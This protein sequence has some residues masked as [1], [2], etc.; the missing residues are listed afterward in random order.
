LPNTFP[1]TSPVLKPTMSTQ[2]PG[3]ETFRA[4]R[5]TGP[6][7][8]ILSFI[9]YLVTM[10]TYPFPGESARLVA[11]HTTVQP[12][13]ELDHGIWL[14]VSRIA[15]NI[16]A[17]TLA[18]RLSLFSAL[19]AAGVVYLVFAFHLTLV[20]SRI[21]TERFA[22]GQIVSPA[23]RE[24]ASLISAGSAAA[25]TATC[26][27]FWTV[28]NRPHYLAF[29]IFLFALAAYGALLF[30]HH[31]KQKHYYGVCL[32]AGLAAVEFPGFIVASPLIGFAIVWGLQSHGRLNLSTLLK[33]GIVFLA[34]FSTLILLA[35]YFYY[36]PLAQAQGLDT[37]REALVY[38]GYKH[39]VSLVRS[40]P[41]VGWLLTLCLCV[42]PWILVVGIQ[43]TQGGDEDKQKF[44]RRLSYLVLSGVAIG[45]LYG[46]PFS[47]WEIVKQQNT[48]VLPV[49]F[50]GSWAGFLAGFWYI[51]FS[52]TPSSG[53]SRPGFFRRSIPAFYIV[54]LA[55]ILLG[56]VVM[57][58]RRAD[59]S[60]GDL[61]SRYADVIVEK[62]GDRR[63]V[64]GVGNLLR[65]IRIS[66]HDSGRE[67]R[68]IDVAMARFKPYQG[69]LRSLHKDPDIRVAVSLGIVPMMRE[70]LEKSPD[71]FDS[72][73]VV[74]AADVLIPL[75]LYPIPEGVFYLPGAQED[76]DAEALLN[77]HRK[78]WEEVSFLW[79]EELS[80]RNI[81]LIAWQ[82]TLRL[83]LAKNA[84]NLGVLMEDL[85]HNPLAIIA[86]EKAREINPDNVSALLNLYALTKRLD[87]VQFPI[88]EKEL[89]DWLDQPSERSGIWMLSSIDGYVRNPVVFRNMG[90][91][92]AMSGQPGRAIKDLERAQDL[93]AGGSRVQG[94]LGSLY[95]LSDDWEKSEEQFASMLEE[96]P[97]SVVG[98]VG[99]A[100]LSAA[101]RDLEGARMLLMKA[102]DAGADSSMIAVEL[103]TVELLNGNVDLGASLLEKAVAE[104]PHLEWPTALLARIRASEDNRKAAET[105]L[106]TA[107]LEKP[108]EART[109]REVG[110]TH[111]MLGNLSDARMWYT[112][113]LRL[114][115]ADTTTM[116]Y[117]VQLDLEEGRIDLAKR[118]ATKLVTF[119]SENPTAR[120]AL[121]I[122]Y[123]DRG[124]NE[125]AESH[126]RKSLKVRPDPNAMN[127][128]AWLLQEKGELEEATSLASDAVQLMPSFA[129]AWDT[130]GVCHLQAE[131]YEEAEEAFETALDLIPQM[132]PALL[133]MLELF[134]KRGEI[135]SARNVAATLKTRE[136]DL[137][138]NQIEKLHQLM[139]LLK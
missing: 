116:Q 56:A 88:L 128:L 136:P 107:A 22:H 52:H 13:I 120:F 81:S 55:G 104:H 16:P 111:V 98:L 96:D 139:E 132:P 114:S 100:R 112:Q 133:H 115:E 135:E 86:Y 31:G 79:K 109:Y 85:D 138:P 92:W 108:V 82:D 30:L 57:N 19:C 101:R 83:F 48:S 99:M 20:R 124:E 119:D 42:A 125:E 72:I 9:L 36:D 6:V 38:I 28:G 34:G 105:L 7:L 95:F 117:L 62:L 110:A 90:H 14:S 75:D 23:R 33:G 43:S 130:L 58:W 113:A 80:P 37:F 3:N 66:A 64:F 63:W 97:E 45:I 94:M 50:L 59:A 25:F 69:Y 71:D 5:W 84:N 129:S 15:A 1:P 54:A 2:A 61:V 8:A 26:M 87:S 137:R 65:H 123:Q 4:S 49:M 44:G 10:S 39:H 131:N 18:L 17:S 68:E 11:R 73:V 29:D 60:E 70:W 118:H 77:S 47:P 89:N 126:Y 103:A 106:A 67:V 21:A 53:A 121:G 127:N 76:V 51:C 74:G 122:Y 102:Q 32:T 35:V 41:R 27:P 93:G 12:F 24:Q 91:S 78:V 46:A 40:I 134:V